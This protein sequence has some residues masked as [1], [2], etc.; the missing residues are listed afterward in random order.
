MYRRCAPSAAETGGRLLAGHA[1]H[2][3]GPN[4][5]NPVSSQLRILRRKRMSDQVERGW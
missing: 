2:P 4:T 5:A 3:Q 1:Y